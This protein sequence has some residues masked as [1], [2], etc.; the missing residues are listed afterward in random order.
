[1]KNT[2][3]IS[4][5]FV[6]F[7]ITY[8]KSQD[9]IKIHVKKV[10]VHVIKDDT[11]RY[12]YDDDVNTT[13]DFDLKNQLMS[14]DFPIKNDVHDK[15]VSVAK[16]DDKIFIHTTDTDAFNFVVM[17]VVFEVDQKHNSI[18]LRDEYQYDKEITKEGRP[19]VTKS[20]TEFTEFNI[21]NS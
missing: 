2:H 4:I 5:L 17:K 18:I 7:T 12:T 21:S 20:V 10:R 19:I 8:V 9:R 3:F 13:Y 16:S 1:M 11:L 14:V 6:L 15:Q